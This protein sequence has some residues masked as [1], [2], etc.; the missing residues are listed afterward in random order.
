MLT[1]GRVPGSRKSGGSEIV[2]LSV[3]G[4]RVPFEFAAR[5]SRQAAADSESSNCQLTPAPF[6]PPRAPMIIRALA[7]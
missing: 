2:L 5:A 6:P 1:G 4:L 3:V 7:A